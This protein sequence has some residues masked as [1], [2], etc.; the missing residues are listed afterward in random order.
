MST[1]EEVSPC[2]RVTA[3][4]RPWPRASSTMAAHTGRPSGP[5]RIVTSA[6]T[7]AAI[8][9]KRPLNS[10]LRQTSTRRPGHSRL[11]TAISIAAEAGPE[12]P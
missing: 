12:T 9:A 11:P 8:S 4:N 3:S 6:P 1:P 7:P 2:T 10:P 5:S